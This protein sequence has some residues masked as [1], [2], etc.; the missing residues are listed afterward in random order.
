MLINKKA[1]LIPQSII[2]ENAEGQQYVY[3]ITNKVENKARVKR[4]FIETGRTQ[5]DYIEVLSGIVN[6]EE[7]ID[8]GARSVKDGQ[9]VKILV[10]E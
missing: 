6:D 8:E 9:E 2:S 4:E 1:I 7:I 10:V 5:G 3:T